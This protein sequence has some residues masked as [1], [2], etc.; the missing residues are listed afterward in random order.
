MKTH[1][2]EQST[3]LTDAEFDAALQATLRDKGCF[4]PKNSAEVASIREN[5]DLSGVPT[6][7][8]QKFQSFLQ[9]MTDCVVELPATAKLSCATV[10]EGL[11][12]LAM[13]ARNGGAIT[14]EVRQ[15]MDADRSHAQEQIR[16]D[17][18]DH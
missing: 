17:H 4:F 11:E 3:E 6:P 7:D 12:T 15:R 16:K 8:A 10:D 1:N 14:E 2:H 5:L 9:Q 18:G 13:V